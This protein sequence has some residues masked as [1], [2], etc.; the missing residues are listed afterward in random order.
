MTNDELQQLVESVSLEHFQRPF[1]HRAV[2]NTRLQTTGGRYHLK[3]HHIDVNPKVFEVFGLD[4]LVGVI[5]HELCHYHLHLQQ[6]GYRHQDSDFK[7][8]L[9]QV[10]GSRFVKSVKARRTVWRYQCTGCQAM[11][12]RL[13]RFDTQKY[14]CSQC[15]Q[16]LC[17]VGQT[18][19]K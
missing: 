6:K 8:L 9:H 16:K 10:D 1:R 19:G 2:F 14:V 18:L 12:E 3:T 13:R 7:Q 17:L 4:E 5:K 15:K 11:F